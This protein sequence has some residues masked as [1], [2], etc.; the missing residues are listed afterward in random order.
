MGRTTEDIWEGFARRDPTYYI[1]ARRAPADPCA[2]DGLL[3]TGRLDVKRMLAALTPHLVNRRVAVDVG[4]GVGRL[5]IPLAREFERVV[6]VD[7]APTMLERLR[8]LC[9]SEGVRNVRPALAGEPWEREPADLVVSSLTLQHVAD[10]ADVSACVARIA[11]CLRPGGVAWV[12]VDSRRRSPLY[13][14]RNAVPDPF[15]PALWRKGIR[16]IRRPAALYAALFERS[17][18]AILSERNAGTSRH[19]FILRRM[20]RSADTEIRR[21]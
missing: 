6:A 20:H 3:E 19:V 1:L 15:L 2:P 21:I 4:C 18:L 16:R 5:T 13:V 17:Q 10:L 11:G 14:L 8:E 7:V 9:V 12:Q